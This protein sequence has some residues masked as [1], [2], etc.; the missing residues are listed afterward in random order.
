M[1]SVLLNRYYHLEKTVDKV[2]QPWFPM[3]RSSC[4]LHKMAVDQNSHTWGTN[5]ARIRDFIIRRFIP[6]HFVTCSESDKNSARPGNR[7]KFKMSAEEDTE[8]RDM[9]AQTLESKG[10]LGKIRVRNCAISIKSYVTS[11]LW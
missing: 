10:V 5:L 6:L 1:E 4:L 3:E 8:L 9:V 7:T 11:K 2:A